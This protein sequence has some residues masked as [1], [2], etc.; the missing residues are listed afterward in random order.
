MSTSGQVCM[1]IEISKFN[2]IKPKLPK[3][4]AVFPF[5]GKKVL[6]VSASLNGGNCLENLIDMILDWNK[7]LGLT[8]AQISREEI[9]KKMIELALN[10]PSNDLNL[11]SATFYG[12]RHDQET[13]ATLTNIRHNN[14]RLG[15]VFDSICAGLIQN[16]ANMINIEFLANELGCKR[17]LATGGAFVK[18]AVFRKH[19]ERVF[20]QFEVVYK[21]SSDACLGAASFLRDTLKNGSSI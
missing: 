3:S 5:F 11:S 17:V 20:S 15:Q 6:L 7:Q 8:G 18:N 21:D 19:L 4:V 14:I 10:E 2:T 13:Y 12:E 16:L 1:P 9:W